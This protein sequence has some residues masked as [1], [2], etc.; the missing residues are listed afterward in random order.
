M[1]QMVRAVKAA[2]IT[3]TPN[4]S[5][6][7]D[8]IRSIDNLSAILADPEMRFA[9]SAAYSEKLPSH[10][11]SIRPNPAQFRAAL[12]NGLNQFRRFT[13]QL[14]DAGVP[15]LLGT[16]TEIFGFAGEMAHVELREMITAGLTPYQALVTGTRA[17]GEFVASNVRRAGRFGT[18]A[19]GQ[20]ADL[21]L[22]NAN[23]L[24]SVTNAERID[25]VMVRGRWIPAARLTAMRDSIAQ[26]RRRQ[27]TLVLRFD[28]LMT[29]RRI[30]N[31]EAALR[32]LRSVDRNSRPVALVVVA[33]KAARLLQTDTAAALRVLQWNVDLY[34]EPHSTHA[35]LARV[36]AL[37]GDTVRAVAEARRALA[38]FPRH[39]PA[40]RVL[41]QFGRRE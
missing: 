41:E 12:V 15:L 19:A 7:V 36:Y 17:P 29:A 8:Y 40:V 6:Y 30:D 26:I 2:G 34:P 28:S 22:L 14:N 39:A 38:I 23:P 9:S 32:E 4:M 31:A 18:V 1:V 21:L 11:R 10:N 24:Q 13:K 37:R 35:E 27:H 5:A 16:D 3:V 25:G 20:R 33:V